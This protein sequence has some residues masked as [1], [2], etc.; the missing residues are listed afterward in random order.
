VTSLDRVVPA[1]ALAI[2]AH[3]DDVEF[4]CG[5]T[6]AKW[7]RA[8]AEVHLAVLTDGS[9]GSWDPAT[10][11]ADLAATRTAEQEDAAQRL[12]IAGVHMVGAI[13]GELQ[14]YDAG[15]RVVCELVRTLRP[16]VVLGHDPWR[17]FR[18]HPDHHAAG[19]LTV[20]GIVAA[21]DPHFFSDLDD[22]PHRPAEL[23]LFETDGI[24]HLETID[25]VVGAKVEALLAHRSQWRSTMGIADDRKG[26]MERFARRVRAEAA[27]TGARLGLAAAE[28]FH[29]VAL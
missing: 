23:L 22:P 25:A 13:D 21:R 15:R 3:P 6:L 29:R 11:P 14:R 9:K 26:Q 7:A 20:D 19:R 10:D 12:G 18:V 5:G 4:G 24:D 2:G 1:R 27:A 28:G 16:D 8:G 17:R